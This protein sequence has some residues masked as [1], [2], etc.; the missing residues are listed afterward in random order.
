[1]ETSSMASMMA[2][3]HE[4]HLNQ[5]YHMFAY[6]RI[7]NNRSLV[8]NPSEPDIDESQFTCEYWSDSAYG[9]F[10]EDITPNIPKPRGIGFTMQTF[11][12]S[13]HAGELTT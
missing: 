13:D 3:P 11:V 1:M 6:L 9:E 4:D 2:S 8:F 7:K 5:L 10:S 12:Y